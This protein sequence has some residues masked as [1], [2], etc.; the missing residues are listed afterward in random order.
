LEVVLEGVFPQTRVYLTSALLWTSENDLFSYPYFAP[1]RGLNE[2][3]CIWC[4]G[5]MELYKPRKP[6]STLDLMARTSTHCLAS[7]LSGFPSNEWLQ[8]IT[9]SAP[10]IEVLSKW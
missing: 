9:P 4:S 1:Q 10:A 6:I 2:P 5:H 3:S 8:L 7:L